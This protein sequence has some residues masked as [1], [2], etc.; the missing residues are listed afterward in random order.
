M[1]TSSATA[2]GSS[3]QE[4]KAPS[5]QLDSSPNT[6][7][8][9]TDVVVPSCIEKG[10]GRQESPLGA[11]KG[12]YNGAAAFLVVLPYPSD[13]RRVQAY[14]VDASCVDAAPPARGR[15][16]LTHTYPRH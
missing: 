6:L 12:T 4:K 11:Q 1:A 8:R 15:V 3:P 10:I 14:V 2:T 9:G 13:S 5:A 16:L 7:K